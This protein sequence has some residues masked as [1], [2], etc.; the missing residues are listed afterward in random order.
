MA[1]YTPYQRKIIKRYYQNFDTIQRQKLGELV[2]ELYL[3]E[4]KKRE[5]LWKL[6]GES[7]TKLEFPESRIEHLLGKRDPALLAEIL[8]ELDAR[9]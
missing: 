5:R 6:V 2:T 9:R 1:D 3:A 7:L 4:G 8:K